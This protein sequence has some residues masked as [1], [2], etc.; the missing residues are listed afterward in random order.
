MTTESKERMYKV[1][2]YC[3]PK[4][5]SFFINMGFRVDESTLAVY[6]DELKPMTHKE[7][8]TFK[9]KMMK[10]SNHFLYEV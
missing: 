3:S 1:G 2:Y 7:A 5:V 8:C 9:S 4:S 6:Q 10:P